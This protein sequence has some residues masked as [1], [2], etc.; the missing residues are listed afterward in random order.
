M[1]KHARPLALCLLATAAV[2]T[3]AEPARAH[4][5]LMAPSCASNQDFLGNPQK[6][7]PCGENLV[8]TNA[9]TTFRP[10][11]TIAITIKETVYHPGHYRVL[12]AP[13]RAQ[14]PADPPVTAAGT[15]CGSTVITQNPTPPLLADGLLVHTSQFPGDGTQTMMVKLPDNMTCTNC[16]LQVVQFMSNHA[17]NNPGGCFYHHCATVTIKAPDDGGAGTPDL[18]GATDAASPP[19]AASPGDAATPGTPP[20]GGCACTVAERGRG[21]DR[22][23]LLVLGLGLGLALLR[24]RR[25]GLVE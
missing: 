20:A 8:E 6:A 25:A 10:G 17:L 13:T 19:D 9:V 11:Q 7:A 2:V 12:L 23:G 4:F 16:V 3:H 5:S 18:A 21:A 1:T 24:R 15:P 14:L 22:S